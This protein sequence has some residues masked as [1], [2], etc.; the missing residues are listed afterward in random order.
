MNTG[1]KKPVLLLLPLLYILLSFFLLKEWKAFYFSCPDYT[2]TYLLNGTNLA[3]GHIEIGHTDHPGTPMQCFAAI[4][5][6]VKHL[7]TPGNLPV[8]QDV[9]L[10]P[11][12]Y[13][14][15]ISIA[16]VL[17][18]GFITFLTGTYIFRHTA[19]IGLALTFQLTPMLIDTIFPRTIA[20]HPESLFTIVGMF[21]MAYIYIETYKPAAANGFTIKT[22]ILFGMFSAFLIACRITSGP[23][24]FLLLFLL[25]NTKQRLIYIGS[26]IV[27]FL[28]FIAPAIPKL[29]NIYH[30]VVSLATHDGYYGAGKEQ[31]INPSTFIINLT[32]IFLTDFIFTCIYVFITIALVTAL[33]K[34]IRKKISDR[35]TRLITGIWVSITFIVLVVAK[36]CE[37]YYLVPAEIIFSLG[38]L[39]SYKILSG[40][41]E[42]GFYKKNR[43]AIIYALAG[44][45]A[46]LTLFVLLGAVPI[47]TITKGFNFHHVLSAIKNLTYSHLTFIITHFSFHYPVPALITFPFGLILIFIIL[48]VII[49][50]D[51]Y[52]KHKK[53]IVYTTFGVFLSLLLF[54]NIK[55]IFEEAHTDEIS[56]QKQ[57]DT[58]QIMDNYPSTP[59]IIVNQNTGTGSFIQHALYYGVTFSGNLSNQYFN[60]LKNNYPKTYFYDIAPKTLHYMGS[61]NTS[62]NTYEQKPF[63]YWGDIITA[64][65]IFK[66]NTK[67]LV[68][69][70]RVDTLTQA[71]VMHKICNLND[72][73]IVGNYRKIYTNQATDE[74]V[75]LIESDV[76][77]ASEPTGK[78]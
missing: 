30:W 52:Q 73:L 32:G 2:Y 64:P 78:N 62:G 63:H 1:V 46:M 70:L 47:G 55:S 20:V 76:K 51:A 68:Y 21:F 38:L 4:V 6:S 7:F 40:N 31:I 57:S 75:Y 33:V 67:A 65:E 35:S 74:D 11:E 71:I 41:V 5:I 3:G 18:L 28:V 39:V 17:V 36:H 15:T 69:F 56:F 49:E 27:S 19:S 43:K 45:W 16:L 22:V 24:I 44:I 59:I 60:F 37:F 42:A 9:L 48:S 14:Y 10:N 53:R 34:K 26:V 12:S 8:Y 13:L 66:N 50:S 58:R 25:E 54:S 72:S 61:S 29:L 77:L 23:I